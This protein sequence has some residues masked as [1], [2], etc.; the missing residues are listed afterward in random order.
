[1]LHKPPVD[2]L[3]CGVRTYDVVQLF[4]R[5]FMPTLPLQSVGKG[6]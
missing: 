2:I 4:N 1:M 3:T 6:E 5:S